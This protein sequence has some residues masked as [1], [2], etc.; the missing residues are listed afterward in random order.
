MAQDIIFLCI[1]V[2]HKWR[3]YDIW[4]LKYKVGQT[5]IFVI[6]GHFLPFH[7]PDNPENESFKIKKSPGD[8]VILHISTIND[9]LML[10]GSWDMECDRHN[11]LSFRTIFPPFTPLWTKKVKILKK[12]KKHLK[13]L[14]FHEYV[15]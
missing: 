8:I 15:P 12:W 6:L 7:P 14:S 13:M 2:Y 9:N 5:E 11:F 3:S 4:F 1:H 10:Y